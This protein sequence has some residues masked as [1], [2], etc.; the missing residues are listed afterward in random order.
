VLPQ[1][2]RHVLLA[3]VESA[4][5]RGPAIFASG[6]Y[7]RPLL[8]KQFGNIWQATP[9]RPL[10]DYCVVQWTT[11]KGIPSVDIGAIFYQ[12]SFA[13]NGMSI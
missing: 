11:S 8:E 7:F 6:V 12:C 1:Q 3:I 10:R 9:P 4:H 2:I 13:E 5:K